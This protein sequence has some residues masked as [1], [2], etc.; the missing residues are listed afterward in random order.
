MQAKRRTTLAALFHSR[1]TLA[2]S[3]CNF[4]TLLFSIQ[5]QLVALAQLAVTRRLLKLR[6]HTIEGNY[7]TYYS[8]ILSQT[9]A[10]IT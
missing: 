1:G 8:N 3:E 4:S 7:S 9:M 5:E 6:N 10:V 2:K